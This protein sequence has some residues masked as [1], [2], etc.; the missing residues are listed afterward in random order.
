[1]GVLATRAARDAVTESDVLR[2]APCQS[3]FG[4]PRRNVHRPERLLRGARPDESGHQPP[5]AAAVL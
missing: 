3:G 4:R 2:N 1:L 5:D